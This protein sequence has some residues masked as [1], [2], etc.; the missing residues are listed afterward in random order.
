M[1][2]HHMRVSGKAF[3]SVT[4]CRADINIRPRIVT[5]FYSGRQVNV[6]SAKYV[7]TV[8]AD[9]CQAFVE[10]Q[11]AQCRPIKRTVFQ[12]CDGL[13]QHYYVVQFCAVKCFLADNLYAA[14]FVKRHLTAEVA[15]CIVSDCQHVA[16]YHDFI[17]NACAVKRLVADFLQCV[18]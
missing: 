15:K 11:S 7:D 2:P 17:K 9:V 5:T 4:V 8:I 14:V 12:P 18:G 3:Q 16:R 1:Q 10:Y 6:H 13:R